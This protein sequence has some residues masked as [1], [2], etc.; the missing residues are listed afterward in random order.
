MMVQPAAGA[1]PNPQFGLWEV[2]AIAGTFGLFVLVFVRAVRS[3]PPVP[4]GDLRLT[5]SLHYHN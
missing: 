4:L 3:A 1:G 5:E 2:A